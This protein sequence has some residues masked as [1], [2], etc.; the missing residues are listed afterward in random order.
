MSD[1]VKFYLRQITKKSFFCLVVLEI[2]GESSEPW[3][4]LSEL[5]HIVV[6]VCVHL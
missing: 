6:G 5:H 4:Q 1:L 2:E 3:S